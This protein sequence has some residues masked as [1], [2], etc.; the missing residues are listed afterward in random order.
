M[1][2]QTC[3][4]TGHRNLS[5]D[6]TEVIQKRLKAEIGNLIRQGVRYFGAGGA[7]GFDTLAALSVLELREAHPHIRLILVLP[8]Q[9][10]AERWREQDREL[11]NQILRRADKAVYTAAHY[12]RGCLHKRNRHLVD[13]AD[14]CIAYV[15]KETGGAA[16]T[17]AYA[18]EN[19]LRVCNLAD[20]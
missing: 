14:F 4:F 9:E 1:K 8:Y 18:R 16:Y 5:E 19:G 6:E 12:H 10:Q 7:L 20:A 15:R 3:C 11:Y 13:N 2:N 17:A